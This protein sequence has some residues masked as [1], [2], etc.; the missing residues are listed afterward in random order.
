MPAIPTSPSPTAPRPQRLAVIGA[1]WAGLAAA[2]AACQRGMAVTVWE[3]ARTPGGRARSV[4][5]R[6]PTGA[7]LTL[8]NGQHILI[9]AYRDSLAL[10]RTVGADPARCLQRL[11]LDLRD[12]R[13]HGLALPALPRWWPAA[14]QGVAGAIGIAR[15]RGWPLAER[16]ALLRTLAAWQRAGF[17]CAPQASVAQL[18]QRLPARLVQQL[19]EPLCT[20]ALNTPIE[21]AS[22]E[23]F[24]RVLQESFDG[25]PGSADLLLPTVPL[26]ALLAEPACDWLRRH[27]A[28]VRLGERV[29]HLARATNAAH[30]SAAPRW[31]VEG[32]TFDA[33]IIATPAPEAARL[34]HS[35]TQTGGEADATAH[36]AATATQAAL[37]WAR[38]AQALQHEPIGT[39]YLQAQTPD[40]RPLPAQALA[41]AKTQVNAPERAPLLARPMLAS[42]LGGAEAP[43]Q[44]IF[45]RQRLSGDAGVVAWVA[46]TLR[47]DK[48]ALERAICQQA[49]H[50]MAQPHLLAPGLGPLRWQALATIVE[51]RATFAC[52]TGLQRPPPT[53]PHPAWQGLALCGDY[54]QGPY[55]ATLEGAVRS[56]QQAIAA[57]APDA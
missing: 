1:G 18:C 16:W 53:L 44:F 34:L 26:G 21:H 56:G 29:T 47:L 23:V 37:A 51:K 20:A 17:R 45:D 11:P 48:P 54:V 13:N 9:G 39:V 2:V 46:S 28:Q 38:T 35:L 4:A 22:A 7:A 41:Q 19:I 14:W 24:L 43:A 5:V 30:A 8:D 55:P 42:S 15:A 12:T 33:L 40:G 32:E 49:L 25:G 3:A 31:L 27:G 52:T 10:M 57:L 6:S 36:D 50:E